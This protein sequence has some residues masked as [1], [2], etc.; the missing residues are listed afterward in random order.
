ME[1]LNNTVYTL[2]L[3]EKQFPSAAN[4]Q[5]IILL[6]GREAL[7]TLF[8]YDLLLGVCCSGMA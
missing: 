8:R 7:S 4:A 1:P 6:E 3:G 2:N 5:R